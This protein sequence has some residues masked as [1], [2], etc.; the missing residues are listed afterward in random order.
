VPL[1]CIEMMVLMAQSI[2]IS[3]HIVVISSKQMIAALACVRS[4]VTVLK[5]CWLLNL[6]LTHGYP[7]YSH[8]SLSLTPMAFAITIYAFT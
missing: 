5:L 7:T 8:S 1:Q 6:T 4:P 2:D 3:Y